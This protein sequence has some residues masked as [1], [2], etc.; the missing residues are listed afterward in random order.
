MPGGVGE[1]NTDLGIKDWENTGLATGEVRIVHFD[2]VLSCKTF[3]KIILKLFVTRS[4][5][6]GECQEMNDKILYTNTVN[7]FFPHNDRRAF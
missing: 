3:L 4:Q 5:G 1:V 2:L 6:W 7:V